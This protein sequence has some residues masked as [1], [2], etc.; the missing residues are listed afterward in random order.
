LGDVPMGKLTPAA[1]V[2]LFERM[3]GEGCTADLRNKVGQL[4]RRYVKNALTY[5][6]IKGQVAALILKLAL[7]RVNVQEMQPLD[8][9]QVKRFLAVAARNRLYPLYLMALDTGMRQGE[10][11]ALEWADLDF[12]AGTV[13]VTK[14]VKTGNKGGARVKEAKTKASRRRVRLT[15]R[16]LEALRVWKA[17]TPGR[18][19][20]PSTGR[21]ASYGKQVYLHKGNLRTSF[22]RLL[23]RAGLPEIRFHDLRHTHA[24]LALLKTKNIKAVSARLGHEDVQ[25]TLNTYAHYLPVMEE[26]LVAAMEE[27]LAPEPGEAA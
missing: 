6:H 23:R 18:L 22:L 9:A 19:V 4:L 15:T 25:V 12:E 16:T 14:T 11:M 24:T 3:E 26:E 13:N 17:R 1:V 5:G 21:G 10:L 27:L 7:P 8:E 20:F 2:D